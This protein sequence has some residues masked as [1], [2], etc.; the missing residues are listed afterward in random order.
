MCGAANTTHGGR[1]NA[2][3][4]IREQSTA[5]EVGLRRQNQLLLARLHSV[6]QR[7]VETLPAPACAAARVPR[8][9][10]SLQACTPWCCR[11][12][13]PRLSTR[14]CAQSWAKGLLQG[15]RCRL[16][17]GSMRVRRRS[18]RSSHARHQDQLAHA[19]RGHV[20]ICF[21]QQ[22]QLFHNKLGLPFRRRLGARYGQGTL[23]LFAR[24][25]WVQDE[26][27]QVRNSAVS[28]GC[29]FF[30]RGSVCLC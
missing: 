29:E 20:N 12:I 26:I 9:A 3:I 4:F 1:K 7:S 27:L 8:F 5:A 18:A 6:R 25:R 14:V 2:T 21:T 11:C 16:C 22:L 28:Y 13:R 17:P 30:G 19:L 10:Q 23:Q 15:G 24:P